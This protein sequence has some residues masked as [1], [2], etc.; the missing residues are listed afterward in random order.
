MFATSWKRASN[1]AI[2]DGCLA[3]EKLFHD[4]WALQSSIGAP[5]LRNDLEER[6]LV[7]RDCA[8]KVL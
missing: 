2:V 6:A 5:S 7:L 1:P 8:L 4:L 3:V